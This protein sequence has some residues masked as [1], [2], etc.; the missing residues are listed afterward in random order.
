MPLA[1]YGSVWWRYA[2]SCKR[3][4]WPCFLSGFICNDVFLLITDAEY[5]GRPVERNAQGS[6]NAG[7]SKWMIMFLYWQVI[8][9]GVTASLKVLKYILVKKIFVH[10][11]TRTAHC[12]GILELFCAMHSVFHKFLLPVNQGSII[13]ICPQSFDYPVSVS[14]AVLCV[15]PHL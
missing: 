8:L 1:V 10:K 12:C 2:S 5:S 3:G 11:T 13:V 6:V 9:V 4:I 7:S 14:A 15:W